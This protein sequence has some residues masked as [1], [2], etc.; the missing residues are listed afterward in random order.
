VDIAFRALS[1]GLNDTTTAVMCV[2]YLSAI[3]ADLAD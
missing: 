3:L 2:D 1:P